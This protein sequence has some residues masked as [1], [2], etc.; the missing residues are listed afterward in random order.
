DPKR[1]KQILINLVGNA[2]KFTMQGS[3][4]IFV[5]CNNR[6]LQFVIVDTGI[7]ITKRQQ[8]RLF[9]PFSQGDHTVNREFGGTGLGLAIS[10][11]LA[12]MLGGEICVESAKG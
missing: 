11:R 9:H 10:Q 4:K 1:L 5:S 7:G 3:V 2:I 12:N 8:K 6:I